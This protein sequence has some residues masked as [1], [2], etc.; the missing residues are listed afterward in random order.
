MEY[1]AIETSAAT[2]AAPYVTFEREPLF[3]ALDYLAKHVI[4]RRYI[5]PIL[6]NV[7]IEPAANGAARL[8]G[9]NLDLEG[10]IEIAATWEVPGRF[11]VSAAT[12]RDIAKKAAK[13]A[14]INMKVSDGRLVVRFGR[15][16]QRLAMLP[17]DEFPLIFRNDS[18]APLSWEC[19]A[20][21]LASDIAMIQPA[22]GKEESRYYLRGMFVHALG[23]GFIR[24]AATNGHTMSCVKRPV[25]IGILQM[26]G[27]IIHDDT[28]K[29]I[30][31]ALKGQGRAALT[32]GSSKVE[33]TAG[34]ITLYAKLI[35]GTFPDYA[36]VIPK[37]DS[38]TAALSVSGSELLAHCKT[39]VKGDGCRSRPLLITLS[40][41]GARAGQATHALPLSAEYMGEDCGFSF[42]AQYLEPMIK[43]FEGFVIQGRAMDE[44]ETLCPMLFTSPNAPHWT[45]VCMTTRNEDTLPDPVI[46]RYVETLPASGQA[47]DLFDIERPRRVTGGNYSN[48][49]NIG[50]KEGPRKATHVEIEAYSRDYAARLGHCD[51]AINLV[52][53]IAKTN[54]QG[55]VI[56]IEL[57]KEN[58]IYNR[59]TIMLPGYGQDS[60]PVT[61][62]TL[63]DDGQWTAP[64]T[65]TD[66]KGNI[67]LP[68]MPKGRVKAK[69][70]PST[71]RK[72]DGKGIDPA[73]IA[74][75]IATPI[76]EPAHVAPLSGEYETTESD[77]TIWKHHRDGTQTLVYDATGDAMAKAVAHGQM[78]RD[79]AK[80]FADEYLT[81][82]TQLET[83]QDETPTHLPQETETSFSEPE[84]APIE[85]IDVLHDPIAALVARIEALELALQRQVEAAGDQASTPSVGMPD[86]EPLPADPRAL[87]IVKTRATL[88][89][90]SKPKRT[91]AH[92]RAIMAYLA[93]R[94]ERNLM[95]A[96]LDA[97]NVYVQKIASDLGY[98][99]EQHA[100]ARTAATRY[101]EEM[102]RACRSEHVLFNKRR[103]AV[104]KAREFQQRLYAEY[105]LVDQRADRERSKVDRLTNERDRAETALAAVQAR[106]DGWPPAIRSLNVKFKVAA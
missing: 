46:V 75:P 29:A 54:E 76:G 22:I 52:F 27:A 20:Q 59:I 62:E 80:A 86:V 33:F 1:Q 83:Q 90:E 94:S 50:I 88:S 65:C 3:A 87:G 30:A 72:F 74:A 40:E 13:G 81:P 18:D 8:T 34:N 105:K 39:A 64:I 70:R 4:E 100:N 35:D 106:A 48:D 58:E 31:A 67:A 93:M 98:K 7:L 95:K 55:Q 104:L 11:T 37:A 73:Y 41:S 91:A 99:T 96:G 9:C 78:M 84:T 63:C 82:E 42:D 92:V 61:V 5:E 10:S 25:P 77:G 24:L 44:K 45:G 53:S 6:A 2:V 103:R 15:I 28:V 21:D 12:L 26:D 49:Y 16:E 56:A 23:D 79:A 19:N 69:P 71:R 89:G 36:R 66:A 32:I 57:G 51:A 43:G 102:E 97:A 47:C 68:D 101:K 85:V 60:Q 17:A 14:Q 38:F